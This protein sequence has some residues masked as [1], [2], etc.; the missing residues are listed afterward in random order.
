MHKC[1]RLEM[2]L[3]SA[4]NFQCMIAKCCQTSTCICNVCFLLGFTAYARKLAKPSKSWWQQLQ[5]LALDVLMF[6]MIPK[7]ICLCGAGSYNTCKHLLIHS[8]GFAKRQ[9]RLYPELNIFA[10]LHNEIV[11]VFTTSKCMRQVRD[12]IHSVFA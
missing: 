4:A 10:M 3:Q 8:F 5:N 9:N 11:K 1:S 12:G 2:Y 6:A 7:W